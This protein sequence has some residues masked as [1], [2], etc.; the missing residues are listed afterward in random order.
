MGLVVRK[1]ARITASLRLYDRN[2][3]R[4]IFFEREIQ[5]FEEFSDIEAPVV[6]E[7]AALD[8]VVEALARRIAQQTIRGSYTELL[9]PVEKGRKP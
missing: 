2:R 8:R 9:T 1:R 4:E 3:E 5:A 6:P 7:S